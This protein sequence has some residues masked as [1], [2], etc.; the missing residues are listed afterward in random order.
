M[1]GERKAGTQ[2]K[3]F[4]EESSRYKALRQVYIPELFQDHKELLEPLLQVIGEEVKVRTEVR[5]WP[6]HVRPCRP[7][8]SLWLFLWMRW[9]QHSAVNE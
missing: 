2:R 6:G 5:G 9:E 3:V 8:Y 4:Q 7:L 1:R